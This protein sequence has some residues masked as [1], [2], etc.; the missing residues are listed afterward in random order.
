M[1]LGP[2]VR[3]IRELKRE[4]RVLDLRARGVEIQDDVN[5]YGKVVISRA[6]GS[7]ILIADR[8]IFN[9][10]VARNTLEARGPNILK[11]L[12]SAARIEVGTDSGL[13]SATISAAC[14]IRVGQRV[15]IGAGTLITDSDHH[16]VSPRDPSLRRH[17]AFPEPRPEHAVSIE[18]DVFIGA[19]SM[20]LKGVTIGRGS[21]IGAGSVV[22]RSIPEGVIAA[23]NP[24][25]PL[26][27][28]E[29]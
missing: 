21:V 28:L 17:A 3:R 26:R 14:S 18:D 2:S 24:C 27:A 15:L 10:S 1:I 16:V 20:V 4:I 8:V 13:T 7:R 5:V 23:G 19:R 22:S 6:R 29:V 11:T 12:M 25:R 9:S